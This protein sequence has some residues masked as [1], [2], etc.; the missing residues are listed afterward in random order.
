MANKQESAIGGTA[1]GGIS[2]LG[3]AASVPTSRTSAIGGTASDGAASVPTL[4]MSA[5][6]N[7][8]IFTSAKFQDEEFEKKSRVRMA[9][10]IWNA[11]PDDED[12][13]ATVQKAI[14]H[15]TYEKQ[16]EKAI[17]DEVNSHIKNH[18]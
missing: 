10:I 7:K 2:A 9:K 14:N 16:W 3:G 4:R 6:S 15:P 18:T 17:Q 12:E 13:S 1:S 8:G 11:N 5:R